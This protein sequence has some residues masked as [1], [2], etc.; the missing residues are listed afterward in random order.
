[1]STI[2]NT[3][4]YVR[5]KNAGPFW[6]TIDIFCET[7]EAYQMIVDSTKLTPQAISKLYNVSEKDTK[8]FYLPDLKTVKISIPRS[9]PQGSEYERD[10]HSGQQYVQILDFEL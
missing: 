8:L 6:I 10:M 2:A 7:Q 1:M 9:T 5:S 3:A 4:S